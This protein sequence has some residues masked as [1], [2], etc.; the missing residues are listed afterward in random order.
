MN[1]KETQTFID[2]CNLYFHQVEPQ[3][4]EPKCENILRFRMLLYTPSKKYNFWKLVT[5]GV[6]DYKMPRS[7]TA[8][9][10][11]NEYVLFIDRSENLFDEDTVQWY[12][13]CLINLANPP[14]VEEYALS[15]GHSVEWGEAEDTDMVGAY[16]EMPQVIES[17]KF[18][19]CKLDMFK[20]ITCLQAVLLTREDMDKLRE[21]GEEKFDYWLYPEDRKHM[22]FISERRR[23]DKF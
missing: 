6:S 13:K 23:S 21:L 17:I 5:L 4:L 18:L 20:K 14:I 11:R 15:F 9:G 12:I 16:V 3:I 8:L 19:Q 10:N 7:R 1:T 22:H 2:H